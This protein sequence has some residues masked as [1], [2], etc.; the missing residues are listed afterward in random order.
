MLLLAKEGEL[1]G[2]A[3]AVVEGGETGVTPRGRDG[4]PDVSVGRV[5]VGNGIIPNDY[6]AV[7]CGRPS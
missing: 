2:D 3:E 7:M 5:L 6:G 1:S 4:S